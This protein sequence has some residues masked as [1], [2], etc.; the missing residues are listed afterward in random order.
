MAITAFG[1]GTPINTLAAG[2][3]PYS[4]VSSGPLMSIGSPYAFQ[5]GL[6]PYASHPAQQILQLLQVVPQQLQQILQL[7][8]LQQQQLQQLQYALQFLP[9]QIQ[10]L[11]QFAPQHLQQMQ[12]PFAASPFLTPWGISPQLTGAQSSHVM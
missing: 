11:I 1:L 12:Q 8:H 10:Q 3:S 5:T 2:L 6:A 9:A 4:S 7:G